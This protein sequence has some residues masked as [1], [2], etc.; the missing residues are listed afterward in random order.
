MAMFVGVAMTSLAVLWPRHWELTTDPK[1]VIRT[2]VESESPASVAIV[3]RDLALHRQ[4]SVLRND[5]ALGQ[6]IVLFQIASVLLTT[7]VVLWIIAIARA[8]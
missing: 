8:G 2:Y 1:D 6:L 7:E 4:S 5:K 3:H